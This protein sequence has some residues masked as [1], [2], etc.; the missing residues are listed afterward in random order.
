[1]G[2]SPIVTPP[3]AANTTKLDE[4]IQFLEFGAE[5]AKLLPVPGAA[6]GSA[7][8]AKILKLI[9]T[10]VRTHEQITGEPLDLT[11]LHKLPTV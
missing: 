3:R 8:A 10:A 4:V 11:K 5:W 7:V 9:E 1:M 2:S 6:A